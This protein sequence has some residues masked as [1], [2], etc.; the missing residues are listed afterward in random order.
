MKARHDKKMNYR[1]VTV[2][3]VVLSKEQFNVLRYIRLQY[4]GDIICKARIY[5]AYDFLLIDRYTLYH[6]Y[7]VN[8]MLRIY[9]IRKVC[10]KIT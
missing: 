4:T 8:E 1:D 6:H 2:H 3:N 10:S 5:V 7:H 9:T